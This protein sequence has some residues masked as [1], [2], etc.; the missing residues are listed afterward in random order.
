MIKVGLTTSVIQR[1]KTGIAQWLFAL[2]KALAA[3]REEL[4]LTLFVLEE[5]RPLFDYAKDLFT[6]HPVPE[7]C[8]N[9]IKD[10]AW[11]Q[12]QL[13][14]LAKQLSLDVI[15]TPSYRRLIATKVCPTVGTIHDLAPFRLAGKYDWKRML[16]GKYFVPYFARRNTRITAVSQFTADDITR[17]FGIPQSQ[18]S[19]ILNGLDHNRFSPE[20]KTE[21]EAKLKEKYNIDAPIFLYIARIE[22]PGKNHLRLIRA[23]ENMKKETGSPW[24]M[25]FGGSDWHGAEV[26][27]EAIKTSPHRDDFRVTG[28]VPDE[29]LADLYRLADAFVFPSLFEGFGLPPV[30]AMACGTPVISSPRGSLAEVIGDG[31]LVIEPEDEN[32]ICSA[33]QQVATDSALRENLRQKGFTNAQRFRWDTAAKATLSEYHRAIK[34]FSHGG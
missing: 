2:T 26:I 32:S 1:G 12:R 10:I 13:P 34:E 11:H 28:F 20:S 29:E 5:D 25:V 9:P 30:E 21:N 4:D 15:H 17:F 7:A 16:F 8:R 19:V 31:S 23:F 24:K 27:H 14:K 6:I 3:H 22:H 33:L 18:I